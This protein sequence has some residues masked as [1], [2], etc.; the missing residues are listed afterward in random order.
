MDY[1]KREQFF[2]VRFL[3]LLT[4]SAA[5]IDIGPEGF[6]LL[7]VIVGQED[8]CR[9]SRP[10]NFWN[11]Q[12]ATLCGIPAHNETQLRRVRDRCVK[13]GWLQ[14]ES[15]GRRKHG[16]YFVAIPTVVDQ[17][18]DG[19]CDELPAQPV[20]QTDAKAA[21]DV[22]NVCVDRAQ[23]VRNVCAECAPSNPN[24]IPNPIPNAAAAPPPARQEPTPQPPEP[25][26][27]DQGPRRPTQPLRKTFADWRIMVA[28]RIFITDAERAEWTAMFD[29]EGWDDMTAAYQRLAES[30]PEPGKI[31]LSSFQEIRA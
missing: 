28:K 27:F 11:A 17:D 6:T 7:M 2:A 26:L 16:R 4:K 29:A 13:A 10:V 31:F 1:P 5:A 30:I 12:L 24:P 8:A 19:G 15:G 25:G 14:Y 23:S 18:N 3:R 21:P 22:P 9:Y 20:R